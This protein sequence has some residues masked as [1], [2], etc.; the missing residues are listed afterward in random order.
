M[1]TLC[2]IFDDVKALMKYE[3]SPTCL[4]RIGNSHSSTPSFISLFG[5]LAISCTFA[6]GV[7]ISN[8]LVLGKTS[9]LTYQVLGHLKTI[10]ILILGFAFFNVRILYNVSTVKTVLIHWTRK[11]LIFAMFW[12]FQSPSRG[13]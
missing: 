6:L 3:Y 5:S 9:P 11:R 2:P 13:M 7:N 1:F 12:V 8:F 4:A 10:L